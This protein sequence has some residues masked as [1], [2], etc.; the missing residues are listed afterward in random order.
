MLLFNRR[1]PLSEKLIANEVI[2]GLYI[3]KNVYKGNYSYFKKRPK[4]HRAGNQGAGKITIISQIL[5]G[6]TMPIKS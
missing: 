1:D 5:D 6:D 4:S 2:K 3:I